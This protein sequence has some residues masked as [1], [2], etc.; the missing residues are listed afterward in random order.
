MRAF[1]RWV[2]VRVAPGAVIKQKTLD[3]SRILCSDITITIGNVS[4]KQIEEEAKSGVKK[5]PTSWRP[6]AWYLRC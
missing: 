4:Q 6:P 2:V 1:L 3:I 5:P